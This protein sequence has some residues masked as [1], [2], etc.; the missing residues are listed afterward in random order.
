MDPE[1]P[2]AIPHPGNP[3]HT[4]NL[5]T[6]ELLEAQGFAGIDASL[7]ISLFDYDVVWRTLPPESEID[8]ESYSPGEDTLFI[9]KIA[10]DK[11]GEKRF[12]R[13][14]MDSTED[15]TKTFSWIDDGKWA[16]FAQSYGMTVVEWRA[17]DFP[18]KIFDLYHYFGREEI[19]GSSYWEGF[20]IRDPDHD[21]GGE[22]APGE[23]VD[24]Y[25]SRLL[26]SEGEPVIPTDFIRDEDQVWFVCGGACSDGF[27]GALC[28]WGADADAIN[29]VGTGVNANLPAS[30][31]VLEEAIALLQRAVGQTAD[32]YA[33]AHGQ[34]LLDI[35][36]A[37]LAASPSDEVQSY[38]G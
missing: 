4:D 33:A 19:F 29:R 21:Y 17:Q 37:G 18:Q 2:L 27:G 9:Y 23:S 36:A 10:G 32:P 13:Q 15:L 3:G 26:G 11:A 8:P 38:E 7:A 25:S 5:C 16:D 6:L 20:A 30:F 35:M 22:P 1:E 31:E 28:Q 12:D 14:A 34:V 24:D